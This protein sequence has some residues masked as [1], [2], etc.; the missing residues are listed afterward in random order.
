MIGDSRDLD[1]VHVWETN[2]KM[3]GDALCFIWCYATDLWWRT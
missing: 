3:F 1:Y 2:R